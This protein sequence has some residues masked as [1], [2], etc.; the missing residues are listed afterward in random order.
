MKIALVT[1]SPQMLVT[2][3]VDELRCNLARP[4]PQNE[5]LND[6]VHV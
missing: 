6:R 3:R 1:L 5:P 4:R 2:V